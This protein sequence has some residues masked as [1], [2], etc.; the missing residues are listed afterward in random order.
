[1][2]HGNRPALMGITLLVLSLILSIVCNVIVGYNVK[3]LKTTLEEQNTYKGFQY[4]LDW[5]ATDEQYLLWIAQEKG[6]T[7]ED[8][9]FNILVTLNRCFELGYDVPTM[10]EFE[11]GKKFPDNFIVDYQSMEAMYMITHDKFDNSNGSLRYR[12]AD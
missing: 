5:G 1:M 8:R 7:T 6:G 12:N 10:V 4:S 9:A 11:L 2:K 3:T